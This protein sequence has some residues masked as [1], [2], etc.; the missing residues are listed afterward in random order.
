VSGKQE[1]LIATNNELKKENKKQKS[2]A[3]KII[4]DR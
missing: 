2:A 4:K 1:D 3:E